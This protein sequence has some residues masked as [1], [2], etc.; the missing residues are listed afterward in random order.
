[1][2]NTL[3]A[4]SPQDVANAVDYQTWK[5]QDADTAAAI[6]DFGTVAGELNSYIST[7]IN[8][9]ATAEQERIRVLNENNEKTAKATWSQAGKTAL[10]RA[11]GNSATTGYIAW[12]PQVAV[13]EAAWAASPTTISAPTGLV[14]SE[15]GAATYNAMKTK[16]ADWNAKKEL[17]ATALAN[18][19]PWSETYAVIGRTNAASESLSASGTAADALNTEMATAS[20]AAAWNKYASQMKSLYDTAVNNEALALTAYWNSIV[21]YVA[22]ATEGW[23]QYTAS[24]SWAGTQFSTANQ[25]AVGFSATEMAKYE[26]LCTEKTAVYNEWL[27]RKAAQDEI[28][29]EKQARVN[30][31][32]NYVDVLDACS[33]SIFRTQRQ[34]EYDMKIRMARDAL[35]REVDIQSTISHGVSKTLQTRNAVCA[36]YNVWKAHNDNYSPRVWSP[37]VFTPEVYACTDV[38]TTNPSSYNREWCNG[39]VSTDNTRPCTTTRAQYDAKVAAITDWHNTSAREEFNRCACGCSEFIT[40]FCDQTNCEIPAFTLVKP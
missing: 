22:D 19:Q 40:G 20:D 27:S 4:A 37:N 8:D 2:K 18:W 7:F 30:E 21:T 32:E 38:Y 5:S 17:T 26:P 1:M 34:S 23:D 16:E 11:Y 14:Y 31:W 29:A 9:I 15:T 24:E 12:E 39:Q 35:Q 10:S 25:I 28:V 36:E 13:V 33:A 3:A 6:T